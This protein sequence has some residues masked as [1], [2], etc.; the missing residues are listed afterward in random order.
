MNTCSVRRSRGV[1]RSRRRLS[2]F[3]VI[4]ALITAL[5]GVAGA[6]GGVVRFNGPAGPFDVTVFTAPTPLRAGPLDISVLVRDR[7]DRRPILDAQV[8]V[9]LKPGNGKGLTVDV[10]ATRA[11]A[12]N[13]LLY[14]AL[15]DLPGPG[16]WNMQVKVRQGAKVAAVSQRFEAARALP[17]LLA[18]WPYLG[19]PPLAVALFIIHQR[20]SRPSALGVQRPPIGTTA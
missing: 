6:D 5:A 3:L 1:T 10:A 18:F 17:P 11:Q 15:V 14:A 9:Q 8:S 16:P 12:T 19:L 7:A 13:K 4:A 2:T 20:L